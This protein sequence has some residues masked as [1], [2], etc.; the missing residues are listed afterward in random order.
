MPRTGVFSF[1]WNTLLLAAGT[2]HCTLYVND[3]PLVKK[4]V[5]LNM[6]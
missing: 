1:R 4:A 6:R 5:K 2:Y 3:E